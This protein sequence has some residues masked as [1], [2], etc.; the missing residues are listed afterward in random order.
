M[1]IFAALLCL[2]GIA[3]FAATSWSARRV[4][5]DEVRMAGYTASLKA[6]AADHRSRIADLELS[7]AS[8]EQVIS[9]QERLIEG[10]ARHLR[11]LDPRYVG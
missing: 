4:R 7:L 1:I 10:Q 3:A 11:T 8:R 5:E 6:V 9:A 2:T